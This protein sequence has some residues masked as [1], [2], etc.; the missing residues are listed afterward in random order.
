MADIV[1]VGIAGRVYVRFNTG[2]ALDGMALRQFRQAGA[3]QDRER[4]SASG[5]LWFIGEHMADTARAVVVATF[6]DLTGEAITARVNAADGGLVLVSGWV[7]VSAGSSG[8]EYR[9]PFSAAPDE[10]KLVSW[11]EAEQ[12]ILS[13][14]SGPKVAL[15]ELVAAAKA[16]L[17][18]KPA[19]DP[20]TPPDMVPIPGNTFPV[21][22]QL[23]KLGGE[24]DKAAGMW[25]VP[26]EA[27]EHARK[28]V[29]EAVKYAPRDYSPRPL[30][31]KAATDRQKNAIDIMLHKLSRFGEDG[32][33]AAEE[34]RAKI[35]EAG[36]WSALT[37]SR[38]SELISEL[39]G[40]IADA[41]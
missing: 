22:S 26:R 27:A 35:D 1:N 18:R 3:R 21:R 34:I 41:E 20:F 14:P 7:L 16:L 39:E 32:A 28:I 19:R 40:E 37:I 15:E 5:E 38:A 17:N 24:F 2:L 30:N 12:A 11:T 31:L 9:N 4:S 29:A 25:K 8:I 36:G 6:G 13:A 33:V 23:E 10:T